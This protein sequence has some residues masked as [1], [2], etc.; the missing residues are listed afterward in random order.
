MPTRGDVH[1][2]E[3]R[4]QQRLEVR[5]ERDRFLAQCI[6]ARAAKNRKR[7]AQ[8]SE[9]WPE[10][11]DGSVAWTDEWATLRSG[12]ADIEAY[13]VALRTHG[14]DGWV[15]VEDFSTALPLEQRTKENL[16]Y[17]QKIEQRTA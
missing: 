2:I 6:H 11:F 9:R 1:V 17:L 16:A 10:R 7:H 13:F 15:T 4:A 8:R 14:Y 5:G 12:Q 3:T